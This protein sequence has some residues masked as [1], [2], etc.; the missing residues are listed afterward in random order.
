M[1]L[2]TFHTLLN[3]IC[4]NTSHYVILIPFYRC[5]NWSSETWPGRKVVNSKFKIQVWFV[6][7]PK[8]VL[9]FN[10]P[11]R[12]RHYSQCKL[13]F[14]SSLK[15]TALHSQKGATLTKWIISQ[16]YVKQPNDCDLCI[17][18]AGTLYESVRA[19]RWKG[20]SGFKWEE[21]ENGRKL[22]ECV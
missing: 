13:S 16:T 17:R 12:P 9:F 22:V 5:R 19:D 6:L 1:V 8:F 20:K 14:S 15:H 4:H 18:G 7:T 21:V 11:L 3:F 10:P 2:D